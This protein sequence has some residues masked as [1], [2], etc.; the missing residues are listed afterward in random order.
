VCRP[1]I[2]FLGAGK[3]AVFNPEIRKGTG[4][5]MNMVNKFSLCV[6]ILN[7]FK[8]LIFMYGEDFIL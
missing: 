3:P 8:I 7:I 5:K 1:E 4:D 2:S 6:N